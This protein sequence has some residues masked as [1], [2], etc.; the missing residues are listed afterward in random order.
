MFRKTLCFLISITILLSFSISVSATSNDEYHRYLEYVEQGILGEDITFTYWKQIRDRS[1]AFANALR[2]SSEFTLVYDSKSP[3]AAYSTYS[4]EAGD[5]FITNGG[6]IA[7]IVGHSG[8]AIS[9]SK[10]LHIAG[11]GSNPSKMTLSEWNAEYTQEDENSWTEIYRP[12][13]STVGAKAAKWAKDTYEGSN[14]VYRISTDP[15]TT[16]ETYCSKLVWQAYYYGANN[17][18]AITFGYIMPES[19]PD[20]IYNVSLIKTYTYS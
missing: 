13:D 10:I 19:L 6:I 3:N 8:I 5:I 7:E 4:M 18:M 15:T 2:S 16:Y 17:A 14:A 9:S 12:S 1:Q 11:I 20:F